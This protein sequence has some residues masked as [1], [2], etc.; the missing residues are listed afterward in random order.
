MLWA[1]ATRPCACRDSTTFTVHFRATVL[2]RAVIS[3][4][5]ARGQGPARGTARECSDIARCYL[6]TC[7]VVTVDE[8]RARRQCPTGRTRRACHHAG[9]R[10]SRTRL[11]HD[12][13]AEHLG[14]AF[15]AGRRAQLV[16]RLLR[17]DACAGRRWKGSGRAGSTRPHLP[18]FIATP[19]LQQA[20]T[21]N[22]RRQFC[23]KRH[24]Q[25]R[26]SWRREECWVV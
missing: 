15:A 20:L 2:G 19:T 14:L 3:C 8:P 12:A 9:A 1:C 23:G 10:C 21:L 25:R 16:R 26:V 5:S 11:Q 17:D 4:K 6:R 13:L 7:C 18:V 24:S 22:R